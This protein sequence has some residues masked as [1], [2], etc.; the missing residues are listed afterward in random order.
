M[1]RPPSV[2]RSI[3]AFVVL[4]SALVVAAAMPR[5]ARAC[6]NAVMAAD[7]QVALLVRAEAALQEGDLETA[8]ELASTVQDAEVWSGYPVGRPE[9]RRDRASRIL[10]LSYVRDVEAT[11]EEI[12]SATETLR[13]RAY[14]H[15]DGLPEPSRQA[16]HAEAQS[17][18]THQQDEAFATLKSLYDRDLLGSPYAIGA[19]QR[20]SR[21]RGNQQMAAKAFET[22]SKMIGPS[23]I[24]EGRYPTRPLLR[25]EPSGYAYPGALFAIALAWRLR[26]SHRAG[27]APAPWIG[28]A[29]RLQTVVIA[30]AGLYL[31]T[32]ALTP[33]TTTLVV[34]ALLALAFW[35]ER[36]GFFAA[37]RR[38]AV[39]GFVVR[40]TG[41]SDAHLA[42]LSFL[43]GA[44]SEETLERIRE[45]EEAEPGYRETARGPS[46]YRL[47]P[48]P[49]MPA[50]VYGAVVIATMLAVGLLAAFTL[51]LRGG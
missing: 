28:Y 7:R 43:T 46:L 9:L 49:R 15:L 2:G 12:V 32:H 6:G 36:R 10:A 1:G 41:P 35:I 25:G 51:A 22:C 42:P 21:T 39:P 31:F 44:R 34:G 13:V 19:L 45:A 8:R 27:A 29:T 33:I 24:C 5:D 3:V 40:A 30:I 38:G 48:K 20:L 50:G 26:R 18:L 14:E 37:V 47:V 17:R 16:E 4:L 11:G 23:Y